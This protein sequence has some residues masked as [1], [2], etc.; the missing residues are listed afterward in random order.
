MTGKFECHYD[1]KVRNGSSAIDVLQSPEKNYTCCNDDL[2]D[3]EVSFRAVYSRYGP[4][5]EAIGRY[6]ENKERKLHWL[7]YTNDGTLATVG[8]DS[9]FPRNGTRLIFKFGTVE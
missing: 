2:C 9:Y 5:V 3:H 6:E 1:V 4:Y 7:M 8:V